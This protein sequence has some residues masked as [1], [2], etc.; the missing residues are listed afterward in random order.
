LFATWHLDSPRVRAFATGAPAPIDAKP[1]ATVAIPS[2]WTALVKQGL[3]RAQ[4]VQARVRAE[5][6][7]AFDEGLVCAGFERGIE[8]STYLLFDRQKVK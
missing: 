5:F 7:K 1:A 3:Q 6:K 8:Q 4:A 2:D